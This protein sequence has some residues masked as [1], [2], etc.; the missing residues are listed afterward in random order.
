M[1]AEPSHQPTATPL[2]GAR[3]L[4]IGAGTR[5]IQLPDMPIGNG[6]A[7]SVLAARQGARVVCSDIEEA[8]AQ[9]TADMIAGEGG[10]A[11][12]LAGDVADPDRATSLVEDAAAALGGG[13]DGLV[14]NPGV[15]WGRGIAGTSASDWDT[16]M[17]INLRA[18]FLAIKAALPVMPEGGSIVLIGSIAGLR[19]GSEIPS[20]DSSKAALAG[21]CRA[22][23]KEAAPQGIR[24]NVVAPGLID[25]TLGR[26]GTMV[27]PDRGETPIPLGRQGTAWEVAELVAF[28]LSSRAS[29]VTGQIIGI[30][31]GLTI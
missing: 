15:A 12:V 22:A 23:A 2:E 25:T 9:V 18:P 26:L 24:V 6:R 13:L 3:L 14:F 17:E 27:R 16:V 11:T 7:I 19:A 8:W 30:D 29:Y 20:Y 31:G 10:E 28:L 5:D 21:L 4:V 1:S